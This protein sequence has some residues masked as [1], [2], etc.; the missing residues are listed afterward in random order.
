MTAGGPDNETIRERIALLPAEDQDFLIRELTHAG[1]SR[2]TIAR[3]LGFTSEQIDQA[4]GIRRTAL[5]LATRDGV[6]I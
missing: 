2:D 4:L 6:R 1:E 5:R 3:S